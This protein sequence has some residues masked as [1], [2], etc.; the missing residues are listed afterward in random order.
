MSAFIARTMQS[1]HLVVFALAGIVLNLSPGPDVL[2]VVRHALRSGARA[3]FFAGLGV[4]AGC[5]V[6]VSAGAFG[7]SALLG[8]SNQAF[9]LLKWLGAAYLLYVAC[10]LLRS[11]LTSRPPSFFADSSVQPMANARS[12]FL[13]GFGTN[14]LNPKVALFF[15]AFVPQFIPAD[16]K[17]KP[18]YFL[19]LGAL[20]TVNG[21]L[22][23]SAYACGA[24]WMA[25]RVSLLQSALRVL[26]GVAACMFMAFGIQLALADAPSSS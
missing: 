8:G 21:L 9:A 22:V 26:D 5:L 12:V 15:L 14:V 20:F 23:S 13:Q 11:A 17:D 6:H 24:A 18:L 19:A 1:H 2:L 4:A 10:G 16:A 3:G 7:L 25:R